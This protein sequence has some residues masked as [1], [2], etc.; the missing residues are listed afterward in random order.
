MRVATGR[1]SGNQDRGAGVEL[2]N[3]AWCQGQVGH[4]AIARAHIGQQFAKGLPNG[5]RMVNASGVSTQG[6]PYLHVF[7]S[8]G[9]LMPGQSIVRTLS[10]KGLHPRARSTR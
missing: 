6:Y 8:E 10:F 3:R 9:V 5:V 4:A 1:L 7:L 2:Q